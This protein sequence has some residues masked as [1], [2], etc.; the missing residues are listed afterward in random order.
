MIIGGRCIL[1]LSIAGLALAL[2]PSVA[3][4]H[5]PVA[6]IAT[7]Y[8]ARVGST[9]RGFDARVIDGDQRM[10]LRVPPNETVLVLDYRSAPYLRFSPSGVYV[11][12]NSAMYYLNQTPVAQTPPASLTPTTPPN[13]QQVSGSHEY[14][15]HD[16]R[17]HALA[18]V[19]LSPGQS[20]VGK[21]AIP[22]VVDGRRS[23]IS[24][25]LWH[26][27][28]PS[29]AWFW[30]VIVL[31]SCVLAAWRVRRPE[32]DFGV[33]RLLAV[34]A[35]IATAA[36]AAGR[37]LHGRPGLSAFSVI[38]FAA[39]A[40]FVIWALH[41]VLRRDPGYFTFFVISFIAVW[42]GI[43]LIPT[44]LNGFVL[45]ALPAFAARAAAVLCLGA[46]A[47]LLLLAFRLVDRAEPEPADEEY[48]HE[49]AGASESYA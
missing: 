29:I 36:A 39:I 2:S 20:Y 17:L 4:A 43:E 42:Q 38:T 30:P 47:G 48:Q 32:L 18:A 26:T 35:L 8:L 12:Q 9:P 44:L 6:P 13:W 25:G 34:V 5:G 22:V 37:D 7:G 46:G 19:V 27:G 14:E 28:R 10:W 23:S 21:W 1:A 33:A 45:A 31:L 3:Q 16:G 41:R 49:D 24:G 11:N 40:V 15:W